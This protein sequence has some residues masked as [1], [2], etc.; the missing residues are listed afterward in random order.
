MAAFVIF[1]KY[2]YNL[3]HFS[4]AA[5]PCFVVTSRISL[6][7]SFQSFLM[8][9]LL[10]SMLLIGFIE[11]NRFF[12][13]SSFF[14]VW[15]LKISSKSRSSESFLRF[16]TVFRVFAGVENCSTTTILLF[17]CFLYEKT[18][19]SSKTLDVS[20]LKPEVQR[21]LNEFFKIHRHCMSSSAFPA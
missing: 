6:K 16:F 18:P 2:L 8:L 19:S 15:H 10:K 13:L 11:N 9:A 17:V 12:E 5:E 1:W 20:K 7:M 21:T 4:S 3:Q 14:V